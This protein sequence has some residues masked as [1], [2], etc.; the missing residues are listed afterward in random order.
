MYISIL[1]WSLFIPKKK[2]ENNEVDVPCSSYSGV[3]KATNS[4]KHLNEF[5]R[6]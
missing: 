2:L 4:I 5:V 1:G 6:S 3:H